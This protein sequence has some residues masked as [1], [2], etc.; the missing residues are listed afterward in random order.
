M[1][2]N[3]NKEAIRV[4]VPGGLPERIIV[5]IKIS[6]KYSNYENYQIM[7]VPVGLP[8]R[9]IVRIKSSIIRDLVD[10]RYFPNSQKNNHL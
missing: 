6:V 3:D 1:I 2:I 5:R 4:N 7:N 10:K 9:I 8:E